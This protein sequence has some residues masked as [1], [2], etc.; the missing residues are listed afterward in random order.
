MLRRT[1]H[2]N[3][4]LL[5]RVNVPEFG[6]DEIQFWNQIFISQNRVK[7]QSSPLEKGIFQM[8]QIVAVVIL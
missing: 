6:E 5:T 1:E 7:K 3:P 8:K 4:H 2:L